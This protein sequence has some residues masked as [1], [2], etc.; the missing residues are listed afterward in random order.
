M[1]NVYRRVASFYQYRPRAAEIVRKARVE[2][3]FRQLA[4][5][6]GSDT[7]LRRIWGVVSALLTY[8]LDMQLASFY[9]LTKYDYMEAFYQYADA[10]P[11][12][13][14]NE[15]NVAMFFDAL[16][17]F[18]RVM[19]KEDEELLETF[20][21]G[22]GLFSEGGQFR[23]PER[24]EY[25][26]FCD[27]L[28]HMED[29]GAEGVEHLNDILDRLISAMSTYFRRKVFKRDFE[30]AAMLYSGPSEFREEDD[31][32]DFWFGFWDYFFFDY[33]L[34][35]EDVT[36]IRFF[37]EQEKLRLSP[38]ER[39][40]LRDLTQAR[41]TVFSVDYVDENTAVC[42][43]LFSGE[44]MELPCPDAF[45]ADYRKMVFFGH[46][47]RRGVMLLNYISAAPA[48]ERLRR[49]IKDEVLRQF[50]VFKHYQMPQATLAEFFARHAAAAR[51]TIH[52][53]S[54][55]AQIK[56][57]PHEEPDVPERALPNMALLEPEEGRLEAAA[58][59]LNFS[60]YAI[61][62]AKRLYEDYTARVKRRGSSATLAAA[63]LL[64]EGIN[65]LE[66]I[67]ARQIF[68]AFRTTQE[69][70]LAA[71]DEIGTAIGCTPLDP[72][73]LTE[74]GYV[75]RIYSI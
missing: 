56:V 37:F 50:E 17:A 25:D 58:R 60:A 38:E 66:Y 29:I 24:Q 61:F 41:F 74:E 2:R 67:P 6:G 52:V 73:Y 64:I 65:G 23:L 28:E 45:F 12:L 44:R 5:A 54:G 62:L 49:R 40:V 47:Q 70:V 69:E 8:M 46:L 3:Y 27:A 68:A 72:R 39:Y 14:L 1:D 55:F 33:H 43:N 4:W 57:A 13:R 34:M 7:G 63:L 22:R 71:A 20:S 48:S 53:L 15:K 26:E 31:E 35:A 19:T 32:E 30:R 21:E 16:E 75:Q 51:H 10:R 9:A 59:K 42:T 18:L 11:R 36:P